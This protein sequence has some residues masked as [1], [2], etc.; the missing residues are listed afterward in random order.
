MTTWF[1]SE[2][3]LLFVMLF[4]N[5]QHIFRIQWVD[6]INFKVK[7]KDYITYMTVHLSETEC[8]C[9]WI[10]NSNTMYCFIHDGDNMGRGMCVTHLCHISPNGLGQTIFLVVNN[11]YCTWIWLWC[12]HDWLTCEQMSIWRLGLLMLH[13]IYKLIC[14]ETQC[15]IF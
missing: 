6:F 2:Y 5:T 7:Y 8:L 3:K 10:W 1:L 13:I 15:M 11:N 4:V 9:S 14:N 12:I